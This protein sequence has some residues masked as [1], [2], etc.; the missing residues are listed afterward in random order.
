MAKPRDKSEKRNPED[1]WRNKFR[2]RDMILA[3]NIMEVIKLGTA[4]AAQ[5]STKPPKFNYSWRR[6]KE[7]LVELFGGKVAVIWAGEGH[8]SALASEL[9]PYDL[10]SLHITLRANSKVLAETVFDFDYLLKSQFI[11]SDGAHLT[12]RNK[13]RFLLDLLL[14]I[15]RGDLTEDMIR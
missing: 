9:Y 3:L 11:W 7:V 10:R 4:S 13:R 6:L 2:V 12:S 5:R 15:D 1:D 8:H 14:A